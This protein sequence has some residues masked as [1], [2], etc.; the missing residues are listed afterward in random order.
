MRC[1]LLII[2]P[3]LLA[4]AASFAQEQPAAPA[5]TAKQ[6]PTDADLQKL[7]VQLGSDDY[8]AREQAAR[9]LRQIGKRAL[10]QLKEALNSPDA[11]IVN[12]VRLLITRIEARAVPGPNPNADPFAGGA[13]P[14]NL[15]R[16]SIVNGDKVTQISENGRDIKIVEGPAG[17][18]M[19]VSGWV[20]GKPAT[21]QY[22]A[23]T[24]DE[25]RADNPE[26]FKLFDQWAGAGMAG[27]GAFLQPLQIRGGA[28]V[29]GP[30]AGPQELDLLRVRLE[31]QMKENKTAED[32]RDDVL[33]ALEKA[34]AARDFGDMD[35]YLKRADDLH[36]VL[37]KQKLDPGELLPPPAKTRLGISI[38]EIGQGVMIQSVADKS[39]AQRIGLKAGDLI[40]KVDGQDVNTVSQLRKLVAAKEKG[41]IVEIR[42]EGEE[43]KLEEKAP[44]AK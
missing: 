25:L 4:P 1:T 33:G 39:R 13:V 27:P 43:V 6:D 18:T 24:A 14:N 26:A 35:E 31:K 17:I 7:I 21:E 22:I 38:R 28:L 5:P 11:E 12:R 8:D 37:E 34:A 15:I 9:R 2:L 10:P 23:A 41:L 40:Q 3:L 19:T 42:R 29:V 44:D 32:A 30:A 16:L 36:T 20:D